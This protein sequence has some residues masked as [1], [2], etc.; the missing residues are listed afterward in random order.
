MTDTW[1]NSVPRELAT[2]LEDRGAEDAAQW[3]KEHENDGEVWDLIG[4][5]LDRIESLAA[6]E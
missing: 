2:C 3:L 6:E 1:T 5:L 4:D